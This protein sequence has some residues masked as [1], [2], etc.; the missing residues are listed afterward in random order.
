MQS[1]VEESK[2]SQNQLRFGN[3]SVQYFRILKLARAALSNAPKDYFLGIAP[4]S[5]RAVSPEA[6]VEIIEAKTS[7]QVHIHIANQL[8]YYPTTI[9]PGER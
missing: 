6:L 3:N 4:H 2:L 8:Q 9:P 5:L 7:G 1:N